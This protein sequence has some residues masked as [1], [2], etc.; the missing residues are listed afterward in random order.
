MSP[1]VVF[2]F[3]LSLKAFGTLV[4]CK[5]YFFKVRFVVSSIV[6]LG[7]KFPTYLAQHIIHFEVTVGMPFCQLDVKLF[8]DFRYLE[9]FFF[10][11]NLV[12]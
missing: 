4:A 8:S 5:F 12:V 6:G 9:V 1:E 3:V 10:F 2:K 11:Q 7:D